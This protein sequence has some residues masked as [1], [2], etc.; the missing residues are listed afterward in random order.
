MSAIEELSDAPS[1]PEMFL[2][3]WLQALKLGAGAL[4]TSIAPNQSLGDELNLALKNDQGDVAAQECAQILQAAWPNGSSM[5]ARRRRAGLLLAVMRVIDD[6]MAGIHPRSRLLPSSFAPPTPTN[7]ILEVS[8]KRTIEGFF[9]ESDS[10]Y[11]I[12]RGPFSRNARGT[13]QEAGFSLPDQFAYLACGVK[14]LTHDAGIA[15]VHIQVVDQSIARGV[16]ARPGREGRE[17]ITFVPLADDERDLIATVRTEDGTTVLEVEKADHFAPIEPFTRAARERCDSD[18]LIAPELTIGEEDISLFSDALADGPS[19]RLTVTGSG[20]VSCGEGEPP[21]N[22]ALV[23][24]ALGSVLWRHSKIWSYGMNQETYE[25]L[26][27]AGLPSGPQLMEN[28]STGSSVTIADI[29]G[30][31]RCIVVICQDVMLPP[32][33]ELLRS[34]QPDWVIVPVLDSGT[35]LTR[36]STR[37]AAELSGE[38]QARFLI[39]SSLTMV[40]WLKAKPPAPAEAMMG[41]GL[42]PR[43]ITKA[44]TKLDHP[45]LGTEV[46][47]EAHDRRHGTIEWRGSLGWKTFSSN[48]S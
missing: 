29:D 6:A 33:A 34:W 35:D 45:R 46:S 41:V 22:Q 37:R 39:A 3:A 4:S 23:M 1:P 42:G 24:N 43:N 27:L 14:R 17:R 7:W 44:D 48:F 18:L 5:D 47:C 38:S 11:L 12:P 9:A 31:G 26:D 15:T 10:H 19:P 30:L 36:W 25:R 16:P 13:F 28:I 32:M 2:R 20:L 21:F 40:H 8:E